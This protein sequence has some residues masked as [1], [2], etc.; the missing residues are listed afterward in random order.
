MSFPAGNDIFNLVTFNII[1]FDTSSAIAD[2]SGGSFDFL[3]ILLCQ[4]KMFAQIIHPLIQT[5]HIAHQH[6]DFL[7]NKGCLLAHPRIF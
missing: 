5:G 1:I 6:P 4:I 7:L 2:F 3:N